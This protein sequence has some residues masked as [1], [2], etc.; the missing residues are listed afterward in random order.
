MRSFLFLTSFI[1]NHAPIQE[2]YLNEPVSKSFS[3]TETLLFLDLQAL[4]G[5]EF[6]KDYEILKTTEG[7][8]VTLKASRK[9]HDLTNK[10]KDITLH[11]NLSNSSSDKKVNY[12]IDYELISSAPDEDGLMKKTIRK[13]NKSGLIQNPP[14]DLEHEPSLEM[15]TSQLD[16]LRIVLVNKKGFKETFSR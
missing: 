12:S 8:F 3:G 5:L 6:E 16:K 1:L 15:Q 9:N 4:H 13:I 14:L 10:V 11:I 2:S 7:W